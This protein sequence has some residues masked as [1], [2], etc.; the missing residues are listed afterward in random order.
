MNKENTNLISMN[1]IFFSSFLPE[2]PFNRKSKQEKK[3]QEY[4]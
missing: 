4:E 2:L 3:N 1:D